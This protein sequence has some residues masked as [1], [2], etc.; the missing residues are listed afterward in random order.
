MFN[1]KIWVEMSYADFAIEFV[2]LL[3]LL[4]GLQ[5]LRFVPCGRALSPAV[6]HHVN[7][8]DSRILHEYHSPGH[9]N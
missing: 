5:G 2:Q 3:R 4:L 9:L 8:Y 7:G 1:R 6:I